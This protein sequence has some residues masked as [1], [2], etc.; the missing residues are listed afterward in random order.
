MPT[1]GKVFL[2]DCDDD[3]ETHAGGRMLHLLEILCCVDTLVVVSRWYGGVQL[4]PDRFK[5]INN[6]SRMVLEQAGLVEGPQ[7][8]KKDGKAKGKRK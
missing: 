2:Q 6:A 4:G 8:T 7:A 3:G 1:D 5:H